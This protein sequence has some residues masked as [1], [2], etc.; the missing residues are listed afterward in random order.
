MNLK[1]LLPIAALVLLGGMAAVAL[2]LNKDVFLSESQV[3]P[4]AVES[5]D[6]QIPADSVSPI[7]QKKAAI[8][9]VL[10]G[11]YALHAVSLMDENASDNSD[12]FIYNELQESLNDIN[13]LKA[14]SYRVDELKKSDD[15]LISVTGLTIETTAL[16]LINSSNKWITYLRSIDLDTLEIPEFQYQM[17]LHQSSNHDAYLTLIEGASLFPMIAVNM[18]DSEGNKMNPELQNYFKDKIESLF[19][20]AFIED[21]LFH[22]ET[23][24]RYAVIVL[25]R[26]YKEFLNSE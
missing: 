26:N 20:D 14:L 11:L 7:E 9:S 5:A 23:N 16:A 24:N 2:F 22:A 6:G 12:M 3:E 15:Q 1:N 10:Q 25:V 13:K 18:S 21:D 4:E 17:A 8:D 19:K